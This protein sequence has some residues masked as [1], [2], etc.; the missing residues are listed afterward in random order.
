MSNIIPFNRRQEEMREVVLRTEGKVIYVD[1]VLVSMVKAV[2]EW[3]E[4]HF[5]SDNPWGTMKK[6]HTFHV[7]RLYN[8]ERFKDHNTVAEERIKFLE[9]VDLYVQMRRDD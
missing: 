6:A 2:E 7:I 5:F 9:E 1:L 3:Y 8:T 4:K